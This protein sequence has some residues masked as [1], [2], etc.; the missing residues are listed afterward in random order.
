[1]AIYLGGCQLWAVTIVHIYSDLTV[2]KELFHRSRFFHTI[3][4]GD[5]ALLVSFYSWEM[6][7]PNVTEVVHSKVGTQII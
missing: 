6:D 1:M 3:L 5:R 2:C 7:F 4:L